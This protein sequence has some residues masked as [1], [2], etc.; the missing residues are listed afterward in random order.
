MK[1][2]L[3]RIKQGYSGNRPDIL[4]IIPENPAAILDVGCGAGLLGKQIKDKWPACTITGIDSNQSLLDTAKNN[5]DT[6]ILYDLEEHK[7]K[8]PKLEDRFDTIIFAD[9]LEHLSTPEE[10]LK[11]AAL[12]LKPNGHIITS[13]PNIRH[14]STFISLGILGTWPQNDRGIHDRTHL[15]FFARK[16]I[17]DLFNNTGLMSVYKKRNLRLIES[18]SWTN[19]PAKALDFWP[20]RS[21]L[22]FQYLDCCQIKPS[23]EK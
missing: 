11:S 19:I 18:Q 14:Y 12:L 16:N 20:L 9:I 22:T 3:D 4:K 10:A 6:T 17:L 8:L 21:F 2:T 7:N 15:R 5:I 13:I 23:N 1:E